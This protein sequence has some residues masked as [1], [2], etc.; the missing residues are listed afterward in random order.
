MQAKNLILAVIILFVIIVI[1]FSIYYFTSQPQNP[2]VSVV[3]TKT[4]AKPAAAPPLL[5]PEQQQEQ[6]K[7]DY[8]ETIT[9]VIN[10]LDV[11]TFFKTTIKTDD[12]KIHE[13]SPAQ[14]KSVYE[15]FGAKQGGKVQLQGRFLANGNIEWATMAPIQGP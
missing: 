2:A 3:G 12:G 10:F 11:K 6:I 13:L 1:G 8:P 5:S 15:S 14:P 9:G 4:I 7:K